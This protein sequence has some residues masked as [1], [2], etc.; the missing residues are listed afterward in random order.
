MLSKTAR[1][2]GDIEA[3]LAAAGRIVRTWPSQDSHCVSYAVE[4]AGRHFFVKH[5]SHPRGIESLRRAIT[6]NAAIQHQAL[7]RLH[8]T[9]DTPDGLALVYDLVPGELLRHAENP[10]A[11][12]RFGR[13]PVPRTIAALDTIYDV[14]VKLADRGFIAVD[15]YDGCFIYDFDAGRMY[16]CDLDEYRRG[17]FVLEQQRLPGSTRFMSP[18]EFV[19]GSVIDQ[20]SNVFT[21]GRCAMVLLGDKTG[22]PESWRGPEA[23]KQVVVRATSADRSRRQ[24]SVARFV[25]EWRAVCRPGRGDRS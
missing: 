16:L 7:P 21:L 14:H 13:L 25:D 23:M 8:T 3:H 19:R 2:A 20:V 4:E 9:I 22:R 11:C 6:V 18:E 1:I 12:E 15:L 24:Q 17:P 5:S 10:A